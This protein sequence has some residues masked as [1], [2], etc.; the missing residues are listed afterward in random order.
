MQNFAIYPNEDAP[1]ELEFE[2]F[3]L[4]GETGEIEL[5]D[6]DHQLI[7]ILVRQHIA[8]IVPTQ[9]RPTQRP[10]MFTFSVYLKN[11]IDE[12]FMLNATDLKER[13]GYTFVIDRRPLRSFYLDPQQVTAIT[14]RPTN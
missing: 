5:Y 7:G 13:P 1:F 9:L 10:D 12:P 4:N 8:A 6:D 14:F 11:H 2:K 3:Q